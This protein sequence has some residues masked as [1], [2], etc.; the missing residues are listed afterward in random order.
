M[1]VIYVI[2]DHLFDLIGKTLSIVALTVG[3]EEFADLCF[4]YGLEV[5]VTDMKSMPHRD[6]GKVGV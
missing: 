5:E 4:D 3:D 2:K 6:V 1:P